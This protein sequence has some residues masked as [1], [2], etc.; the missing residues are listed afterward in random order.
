MFELLLFCS[1]LFLDLCCWIS[2]IWVAVEEAV[3]YII[4]LVLDLLVLDLPSSLD[5]Q[6]RRKRR[7]SSAVVPSLL[8]LSSSFV[9]AFSTDKDKHEI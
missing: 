6:R 9:S 5:M 7:K 1:C 3:G 4:S 2:A 8:F